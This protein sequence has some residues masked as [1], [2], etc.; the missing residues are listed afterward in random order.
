[1]ALQRNLILLVLAA[2]AGAASAGAAAGRA[3][4]GWRP[5]RRRRANWLIYHPHV[6]NT[7]HFYSQDFK[8]RQVVLVN[9]FPRFPFLIRGKANRK[10]VWRLC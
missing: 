3:G 10:Q 6:R 7:F 4:S 9:P 8:F 5:R 2:S 1:M